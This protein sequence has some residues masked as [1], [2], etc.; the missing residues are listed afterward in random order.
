M[1]FD[2]ERDA[3]LE[4][5]DLRASAPGPR[6]SP[7]EL[8]GRAGLSLAAT[9]LRL[10]RAAGDLTRGAPRVARF[11][12]SAERTAAVLPFTAPR[13]PFNGTLTPRRGFVFCS[14]KLGDVRTVKNAF[15][16]TVNDVAV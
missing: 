3:L 2:L 12:C 10:A 14:V 15:G 1:I 9:P 5:P 6:P 7:L 16:V 11:A 4:R 8:L 13:S